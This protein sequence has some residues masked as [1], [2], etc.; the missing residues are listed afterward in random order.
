[1]AFIPVTNTM[2]VDFIYHIGTTFATNTLYVGASTAPDSAVVQLVATYA[3]AWWNDHVKPL[4]PSTVALDHVEVRDLTLAD[5]WYGSA[6]VTPNT[7]T[8]A[9]TILPMNAT[10][11]VKFSSGKAG[12]SYRGRN[13]WIG[14]CEGDVEGD[15]V[16]QSTRDAIQAAYLAW[17]AEVGDHDHFWYIVSRQHNNVQRTSGERSFVTGVSI[18]ST[19]DSQ[20]RRLAGRGR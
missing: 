17:S 14:L 20:R 11:A 15:F 4:Q 9:G 2:K 3:A 7:G 10:L 1:M 19:V 18:E 5:S 13:F 16:S 8:K 12:R 6:T